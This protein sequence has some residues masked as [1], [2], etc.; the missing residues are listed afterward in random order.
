MPDL[1]R[2]PAMRGNMSVERGNATVGFAWNWLKRVPFGIAITLLLAGLAGIFWMTLAPPEF[3]ARVE[4]SAVSRAGGY[5]YSTAIHK[6]DDIIYT[7]F[8]LRFDEPNA[9]AASAL[10]I[11]EDGKRLGPAHASAD[12]IS[13]LGAGRFSHNEYQ[14]QF[15]ASDNSDPRSNGR[16]YS[17]SS[18]LEP[19]MRLLMVAIIMALLGGVPT[20]LRLAPSAEAPA[21]KTGWTATIICLAVAFA[22]LLLSM[23]V[24]PGKAILL[25]SIS[26]LMAGAG[27]A[28][29]ASGLTKP[30]ISKGAFES[31]LSTQRSWTS[32]LWIP[33]GAIA[34]IVVYQVLLA[35]AASPAMG[36]AG[37]FPVSDASGYWDCA[38]QMIDDGGLNPWC[39]RRPLYSLFLSGVTLA[40]GRNL[41]VV[42]L[43]QAAIVGAC[44]FVFAR[45]LKR[46]LGWAACVF[47]CF[48]VALYAWTFVLG[49]TMTETLGLSLGLVAGTLLIRAGERRAFGLALAG[50]FLFALGQMTR[51]GAIF[52]LP[53][54]C[55]WAATL[56]TSGWVS[57]G[58]KACVAGLVVVAAYLVNSGA[59][60]IVGGD[61]GLANSNI[62]QTL[63]GLSI[64]KDW[65]ALVIDHPELVVETRE[66][67]QTTYQ[68]AFDNIRSN[69]S[70][71]LN[72]LIANVITYFDTPWYARLVPIDVVRPLIVLAS[73]VMAGV[74]ARGSRRA[75]LVFAVA[76][77]EIA[78]SCLLTRDANIRVWAVSA[79]LG[80]IGAA[81]LLTTYGARKAL[82]TASLRFEAD[83]V[84]AI[85]LPRDV[86]GMAGIG[87]AMGLVCLTPVRWV[88]ASPQPSAGV[89]C[90]AGQRGVVVNLSA[91]AWLI[92]SDSA[93]DAPVSRE[94]RH[95]DLWRGLPDGAWIAGS[96]EPLS[97]VQLIR[98]IETTPGVS[99]SVALY[100]PAALALPRSNAAALCVDDR[101]Q[102]D[103]ASVQFSRIVS[104]TAP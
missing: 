80:Q 5:A 56:K 11:F 40:S 22:A 37:Y 69:P 101:Q 33:A 7:F 16:S 44:T 81:A 51:T 26:L 74:L 93:V 42:L 10:E 17:V 82:G 28:I 18:Q 98:G 31:S 90:E 55:I 49:Q 85:P 65:S 70:V 72:S 39:Q 57:F 36:V 104:A 9:P 21:R 62:P 19:R 46:W 30:Q 78:A 96:L 35:R 97:E 103:V 102:I 14:L 83:A 73:A 34:A 13:A 88:A 63:Y 54:L 94:V 66:N 24:A 32:L 87:V 6:P 86:L 60:A 76:A 23:T 20:A 79:P 84:A 41:E 8:Q 29:A 45:E 25:G 68:L 12:D 1:R 3:R 43:M 4:T 99:P 95:D 50:I 92:V 27:W 75:M 59:I 15:S 100:A 48:S 38:N 47:A 53:L 91:S 61:A 2:N 64:G 89:A 71:F 77:G 52:A 67:V 58:L